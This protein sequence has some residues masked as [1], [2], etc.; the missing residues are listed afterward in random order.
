MHYKTALLIVLTVCH[1]YHIIFE[2]KWNR[3]AF[4]K[5][6]SFFSDFLFGKN[7][8]C[9]T[10]KCAECTTNRHCPSEK[11]C[12]GYNCV[13]P[14]TNECNFD[15][16]CSGFNYKCKFGSCQYENSNQYDWNQNSG[17]TGRA[18]SNTGSS[19]GTGSNA[20]FKFPPIKPFGFDNIR[21]V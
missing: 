8:D 4:S 1:K 19:F 12:S 21:F 13:S 15:S 11:Y 10:R 2:I 9:V 5:S 16:E 18:N 14:N 6:Y 7:D 3:C 20:A 17:S